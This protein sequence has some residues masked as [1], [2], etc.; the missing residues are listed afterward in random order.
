MPPSKESIIEKNSLAIK[1]LELSVDRLRELRK[2]KPLTIRKTF[3]R[4]IARANEEITDLGLIDAHLRAAITVIA[5]I[6]AAVQSRLDSLA[7]KLDDAIKTDFII[8]A[9]FDSVMDVIAFAEEIGSIIDS[10]S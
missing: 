9:A 5:P 7:K 3:N 6:D 2:G 10:H 4:E 8:N 1:S